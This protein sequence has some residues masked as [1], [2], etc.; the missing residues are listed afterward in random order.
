M[1][2]AHHEPF[3]F[4]HTN[5]TAPFHSDLSCA[6]LCS[7]ATTDRKDNSSIA[8]VALLSRREKCQAGNIQL[9]SPDVDNQRPNSAKRTHA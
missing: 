6:L 2:D 5:A 8:S 7:M 9:F 4:P 3:I 1:D